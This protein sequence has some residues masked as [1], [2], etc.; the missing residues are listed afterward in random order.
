VSGERPEEEELVAPEDLATWPWWKSACKR[1]FRAWVISATGA[2]VFYSVVAMVARLPVSWFAVRLGVVC[3]GSS[4]GVTLLYCLFLGPWAE[5]RFQP[6]H[7]VPFRR[8]I[9]AILRLLPWLALPILFV[10][11]VAVLG[12]R[13][14]QVAR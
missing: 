14:A 1:E 11:A 5:D 12:A 13:G 2:L 4:I 8:G 10:V 3:W 9:L 7:V 6:K